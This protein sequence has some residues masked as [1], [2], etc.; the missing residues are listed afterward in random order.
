MD[1]WPVLSE[2]SPYQRWVSEFALPIIHNFRGDVENQA[3]VSAL[4]LA[5]GA[6]LVATGAG[7]RQGVVRF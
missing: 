5:A 7:V 4:T 3:D 2:L 6:L 1:R